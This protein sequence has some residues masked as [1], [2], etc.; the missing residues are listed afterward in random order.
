LDTDFYNQSIERLA[1]T[2]WTLEFAIATVYYC[3]LC[4]CL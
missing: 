3:I 2:R 1:L 4:Y